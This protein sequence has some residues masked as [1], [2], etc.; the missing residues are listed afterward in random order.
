MGAVED[1]RSRCA[2]IAAEMAREYERVANKTADADVKFLASEVADLARRIEQKILLGV[3]I[4][5]A[6]GQVR[7]WREKRPTRRSPKQGDIVDATPPHPDD[8]T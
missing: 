1:E 6:K 5:T 4:A 2:Y 7:V 3:P 8:A